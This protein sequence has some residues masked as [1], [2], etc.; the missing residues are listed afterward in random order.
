MADTAI[1][2]SVSPI[3]VIRVDELRRESNWFQ[4]VTRRT[5]IRRKFVEMLAL[6]V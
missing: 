5:Y 1:A 6:I 2:I 3:W 4:G